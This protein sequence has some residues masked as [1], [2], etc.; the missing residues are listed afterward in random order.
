MSS[1]YYQI[2]QTLIIRLYEHISSNSNNLIYFQSMTKYT[3][4]SWGKI[5]N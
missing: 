2:H 5:F 1:F 3:K 4:S